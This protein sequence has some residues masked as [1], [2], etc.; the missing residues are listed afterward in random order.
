MGQFFRRLAAFGIDWVLISVWGGVVFAVVMLVTG[1]S[2]QKPPGP[3]IAQGEAFLVM[4]LPVLIYFSWMESS[5]CEGTFGKRWLRLRVQR[6]DHSRVGIARSI[7]RNGLKFLPWE[8]GH[9]VAQ[10]A[11]YGGESGMPNWV[12]VPLAMS[13]IGPIWWGLAILLT[14]RAPYDRWTDT[15]VFLAPKN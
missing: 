11:F 1:G 8:M 4:T 3:W 5:R 10:Q 7:A 12:L 9:V 14:T 15:A 13:A 6:P 2:P